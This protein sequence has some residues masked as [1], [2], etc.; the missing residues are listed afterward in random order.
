MNFVLSVTFVTLSGF[1]IFWTDSRQK[2]D[3]HELSPPCGGKGA[4]DSFTPSKVTLW[5]SSRNG[6]F[7]FSSA[8]TPSSFPVLLKLNNETLSSSPRPGKRWRFTH[9]ESL[10]RRRS[11]LFWI[12][13]GYRFVL[14]RKRLSFQMIPFRTFLT[15]RRTAPTSDTLISSYGVVKRYPIS[16]QVTKRCTPIQRIPLTVSDSRCV[17]RPFVGEPP[18]HFKCATTKRR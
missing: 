12:Q 8:E 4:S 7:S 14:R 10:S 17:F 11:I 6:S 16:A 5:Q 18:P 13:C 1:L 15:K 2:R 3:T 9:L